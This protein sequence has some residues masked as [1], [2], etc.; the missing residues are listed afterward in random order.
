LAVVWDVEISYSH[1]PTDINVLSDFGTR[2]D[3]NA[4]K[5]HLKDFVKSFPTANWRKAMDRFP[6]QCPARPELLPFIPVAGA[7]EFFGMQIDPSAMGKLLPEWMSSGIINKDRR[8]ALAMMIIV[9]L[10]VY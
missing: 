4:F 9:V 7:E 10:L 5:Q 2:Q 3:D 8:A 1:I 6:A